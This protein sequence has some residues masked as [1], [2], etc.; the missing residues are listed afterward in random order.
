MG[1]AALAFLSAGENLVSGVQIKA[2]LNGEILDGDALRFE[3]G[4]RLCWGAGGVHHSN[5][6]KSVQWGKDYHS[7]EWCQ[8][9]FLSK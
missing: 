5:P 8:W 4:L 9:G 6:F 1:F 2:V 7:N 3:P